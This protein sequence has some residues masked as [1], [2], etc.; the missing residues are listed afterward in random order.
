MP[1]REELDRFERL[2][3]PY[4]GAGYNLARWLTRD[5]HD[6]EDVVQEA[7]LR[8]VRSFG[9][10][11]GGDARVW[12]LTIV[13]NTCY[14]WL[15]RNRGIGAGDGDEI[16]EIGGDPALEP[17][18]QVLREVDRRLVREALDGLPAEFREA[19]VLR[20]LEGLSYKEIADVADGPLGTV[21]SRLARARERLQR[22]LVERMKG[23]TRS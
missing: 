5:D 22:S 16:D 12:L 21:M 3:M 23:G 2:L 4:L 14:T 13:R 10:Y 17:E 18:A 11:R 7:Y 15:K 19:L 8:A 1:G 9:Q 6:A 20:E